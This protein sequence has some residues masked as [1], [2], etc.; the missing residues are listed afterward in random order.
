MGTPSLWLRPDPIWTMMWNAFSIQIRMCA[1]TP[2]QRY[3]I[4]NGNADSCPENLLQGGSQATA[5]SVAPQSPPPQS[6]HPSSTSSS[7]TRKAPIQS[8]TRIPQT[9]GATTN[10]T[11]SSTFLSAALSPSPS[12]KSMLPVATSTSNH[13]TSAHSM[14]SANNS[15]SSITPAATS[16]ISTS[17]VGGSQK[18]SRVPAAAIAGP[19]AAMVLVVLVFIL[20]LW[21]RKRQWRQMLP[22]IYSTVEPHITP[23]KAAPARDLASTNSA[24]ASPGASPVEGVAPVAI[25]EAITRRMHQLEAQIESLLMQ[26]PTEDSPPEYTSV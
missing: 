13:S 17:N 12:S 20:L 19:I 15:S 24:V 14:A 1:S 21:R 6:T 9:G 25:P 18:R 4:C 10:E 11:P 2:T 5:S 26:G 22:Q 3:V 23:E 16:G 7:S 8:D